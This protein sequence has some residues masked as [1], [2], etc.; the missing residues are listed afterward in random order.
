VIYFNNAATSYPKPQSVTAA[1]NSCISAEPGSQ[2][3]NNVNSESNIIEQCKANLALLFN[4]RK[5]ERIYFTSG[6]T[7]SLNLIVNG[8][9]LHGKHVITTVTEHNSLLRPLIN[10][11][12]ARIPNSTTFI[13]YAPCD[14]NGHVSVAKIEEIIKPET[15]AVFINHCSNVTGA[16]QDIETLGRITRSKGI[17]LIVDASQSAGAVDIDV[18]KMGVDILVF[19][20]HKGL[21]GIQGTGGFYI[22]SGISLELT[23]VGG[24][25]IDSSIIKL[26][27]DYDDY[28]P[29][30]MNI[31]GI[32]AL[33]SGV[34]FI[35]DTGLSHIVEKKQFLV[36]MLVNGLKKHKN[37]FLYSSEGQS[38]GPVVSF[39]IK[40]IPPGDVGYILYHSGEILVRT[41]LHCTPLIH[42]YLS[43]D[44][45]G[46]IRISF[47][48]FNTVQ[49]INVLL[50]LIKQILKSVS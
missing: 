23:K 11:T 27:A 26:P 34:K 19:T 9:K 41:G 3:R 1:V 13:D 7:E 35:L 36:S 12:S 17:L 14:A 42:K 29:G 33:N 6:A 39:N 30:T 28:E 45:N 8:L 47:S 5:P 21:L 31:P 40:G 48:Y 37:I 16:I 32:T 38:Q 15:V 10:F 44:N 43:C 18:E 20:G 50:D 49:E 24:T 46:N 22:R 4:I 2:Y 25:G